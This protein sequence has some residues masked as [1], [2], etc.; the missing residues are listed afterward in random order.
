MFDVDE[1]GNLH[2]MQS[3]KAQETNSLI[4]QSRDFTKSMNDY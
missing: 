3:K 4:S 1:E 2:I